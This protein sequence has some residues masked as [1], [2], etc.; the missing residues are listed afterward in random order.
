TQT[1]YVLATQPSVVFA[2]SSPSRLWFEGSVSLDELG[3]LRSESTLEDGRVYSVVSSRGAARPDELRAAGSGRVPRSFE[4][5]LQLPE[6]LPQRVHDLALEITAGATNTYDRVKAIEGYLRDNYRYDLDSPVPGPGRDAVDHFLFDTDVGFCEQFA[7]ATAI[8]LRTLGI[9][10]RVAVGYTPGNRNPFTGYYEVRGSDAHSWIEVWFPGYGWYEF[11]PTYDIPP[12]EPRAA[13]LIP[14][15]KVLEFFARRFGHLVP[16]GAGEVLRAALAAALV[17][18][19]S[20]AA[21]LLWARTRRPPPPP[22]V[23]QAGLGGGPVTRALHRLE[24]TL[25]VRGSG[26]A[27]SETAAELL[28]RTSDLGR[29]P[30]RRALETFERERYGDAPPGPPEVDAAVAELRRLRGAVDERSPGGAP[31]RFDR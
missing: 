16:D 5:Y 20:W 23:A 26:R 25:A 19:L 7:S 30:T 2:A 29:D 21:R 22:S 9:P 13:E 12:A 1:F 3:G 28:A 27:P 10:T 6:T 18:V 24:Q 8:L 4:R 15:T 17:G 11:D 31:T 14:L